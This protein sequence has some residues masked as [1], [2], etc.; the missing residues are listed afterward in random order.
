MRLL[1]LTFLGLLGLTGFCFSQSTPAETELTI[2]PGNGFDIMSWDSVSGEQYLIEYSSDLQNWD[3]LPQ[4]FVGTGSSTN[5]WVQSNSENI[6][7]RIT[8]TLFD[9]FTRDSDN[10]GYTD[11]MEIIHGTDKDTFTP[12]PANPGGGG[13]PSYPDYPVPASVAPLVSYTLNVDTVGTGPNPS[14]PKRIQYTLDEEFVMLTQNGSVTIPLQGVP[15]EWPVILDVGKVEIDVQL[16]ATTS[17]N[18]DRELPLLYGDI[19]SDENDP[20]GKKSYDCVKLK[21]EATKTKSNVEEYG[22]F[23][24]TI[25]GRE[26]TLVDLAVDGNRNGEVSF[27]DEDLVSEEKPFHF[28]TNSDKDIGGDYKAEDLNPSISSVSYDYENDT[29]DCLRDLEDLAQFSL[30]AG[31]ISNL[32][33][34]NEVEVGFRFVDV[35]QGTNPRIRIYMAAGQGYGSPDFV[36]DAYLKVEASANEQMGM[37]TGFYRVDTGAAQLDTLPKTFFNRDFFPVINPKNPLRRFIFEGISSGEG[38]LALVVKK[39]SNGVETEFPIVRMKLSN[40]RDMYEHWTVGDT[41][42]MA[43]S[44]I[45]SEPVKTSDS[46]SYTETSQEDPDCIVFVH[47]WRMLPWE[48]R[49]FADTSYKRL[50]HQGFKGRFF[51]FSWPTEWVNRLEHEF[52]DQFNNPPNIFVDPDN[53]ADSEEKAYHS[54]EGLLFLLSELRSKYGASQVRVFSHSM[55]GVVASEALHLHSAIA[56]CGQ[57][58]N[59]YVA[60]Q[61]AMAASAYDPNAPSRPEP[62]VFGWETPESYASSPENAGNHYFE[63]I[64]RAGRIVNFYNHLDI[65][66]KGWNTGQDFKP[67]GLIPPEE[68]GYG[69]LTLPDAF[70]HWPSNGAFRYL[71]FTDDVYEIYAHGAEAR[72]FALGSGNVNCFSG[73]DLN[74][75][76]GLANENFSN[77]NEDHSAQFRGTNMIRHKFWNHLMFEF[78][79]LEDSVE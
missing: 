68:Y 32:I 34:S 44:A 12:G 6:F 45:P 16:V 67:N 36:G 33:I 26:L 11:A 62:A 23:I 42:T 46:G 69:T 52:W 38:T 48:R 47:G 29:I 30:K 79:L 27:L 77:S 39:I 75:E 60:C 7:F 72:S 74:S 70:Y 51:H 8:S 20:N 56:G 73:V 5:Y 63:G 49:Y 65:A 4:V 76:L 53:Y 50:W 41:N 19:Q 17:K 15:P 9:L 58:V 28:W 13:T 2:T 40:V 57:L 10:D 1:R 61:A 43:I 64:E 54:A 3:Y 66:L 35:K 55:G 25:A 14:P 78:D 18:Y 21:V 71:N 59:T 22:E 31:Y 24:D 37:S